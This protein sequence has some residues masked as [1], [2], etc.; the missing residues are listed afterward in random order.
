LRPGV[1]L[2]T[3]ATGGMGAAVARR[4]AND[5]ML[6]LCDLSAERL[7]E[8]RASLPGE[9]HRTIV[10]DI[11]DPAAG[12]SIADAVADMGELAGVAHAAGLSPTMADPQ[13]IID[14]NLIGSARLL[15]ALFPLVGEGVAAV[16]ISSIAGY[17]DNGVAKVTLEDLL[18]DG[19]G[20]ALA[21]GKDQRQA[22]GASK[23]GLR[24]LCA[25]QATPWGRKGA[26]ICSLSPG[27]IETPM[28][29]MEK[30]NQPKMAALEKA[31]P[32]G[33]WGKAEEIADVV[34]FL[35]SEKASF[36]TGSDILVDGGIVTVGV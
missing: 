18:V 23:A 34:E 26:R 22:Y 27:L 28:A 5:H 4:Y 19:A 11:G 25:N 30:E 15:D 3:G 12:K 17:A 33:R 20:E 9:G 24:L 14:V 6:L 29:L 1:L 31:T 7:E 36:V 2:I 10:A 8:L 16:M 21:A 32:L 13:R 35:L